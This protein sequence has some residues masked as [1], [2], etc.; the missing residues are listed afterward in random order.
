MFSI[1]MLACQHLRMFAPTSMQCTLSRSCSSTSSGV[2]QVW[3]VCCTPS[4]IQFVCS[5]L[6][7]PSNM[8]AYWRRQS[9]PHLSSVRETTVH[10]LAHIYIHIHVSMRAV[11]PPSKAL[12]A[13]AANSLGDLPRIRVARLSRCLQL[14]LLRATSAHKT[15]N[16]A[17]C[18]NIL[19]LWFLFLLPSLLATAGMG[20]LGSIHTGRLVDWYAA[21]RRWYSLAVDT[22]TLNAVSRNLSGVTS[23]RCQNMVVSSLCPSLIIT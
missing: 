3:R 21:L 13:P 20:L 1:K 22:W 2:L 18:F 4:S 6:G 23:S 14:A 5:V 12:S 8:F 10:D 17:G 9:L 16:C 19:I 11:C 15:G 7:T